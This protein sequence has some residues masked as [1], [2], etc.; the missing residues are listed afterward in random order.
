MTKR[1][2]TGVAVRAL[3]GILTLGVTAQA[4]TA[5][6]GAGSLYVAGATNTPTH[7][8]VLLGSTVAAE[9]RGVSTSEVG[10]PLPATITVYVKS[11][12]WGNATLTATQIGTSNDYAFN[13]TTPTLAVDGF[14]AC[15]TTIVAYQELGLNSN[16]DYL[17]DGLKNASAGAAS[18]FRFVDASGAPI[19]C[20]SVGVETQ[21]WGA[22]KQI[23][24]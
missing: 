6:I 7:W 23:Y 1:K 22:V 5:A 4:S 2:A 12:L 17:D 19:A 16:N 20:V 3:V 13:Y 15:A 10:S 18:G 14:D 8:N 21:P 11:S 9:I 24:R